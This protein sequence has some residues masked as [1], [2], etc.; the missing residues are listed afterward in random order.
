M[1]YPTELRAQLKLRL[2]SARLWAG[3]QADFLVLKDAGLV[4]V[5]G[6]PMGRNVKTKTRGLHP[7][8]E[9]RCS[10]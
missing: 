9:L 5:K 4:Q 2:Y 8:K 6:F 10:M 1:L 7:E 3:E